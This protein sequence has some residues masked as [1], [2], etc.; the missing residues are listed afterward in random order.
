[1]TQRYLFQTALE[2]W[3]MEGCGRAGLLVAEDRLAMSAGRPKGRASADG[4]EP[5]LLRRQEFT[6]AGALPT[7]NG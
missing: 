5:P 1:M 3:R 4:T 2:T 6:W 7:V